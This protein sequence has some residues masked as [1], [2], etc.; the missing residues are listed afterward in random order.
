MQTSRIT[1]Q[2]FPYNCEPF[3]A[4]QTCIWHASPRCK[5]CA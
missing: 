1:S 4:Y 2:I 3:I 5:R